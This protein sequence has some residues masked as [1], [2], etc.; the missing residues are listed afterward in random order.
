MTSFYH[1]ALLFVSTIQR[2]VIEVGGVPSR[3]GHQVP[4]A[5]SVVAGGGD[6]AQGILGFGVPLSTVIFEIRCPGQ[7]G[8]Q[9]FLIARLVEVEVCPRLL[10]VLR[11]ELTIE[12]IE[13]EVASVAPRIH[14]AG[15]VGRRV[16]CKGRRV[17][18]R[19]LRFR[20]PVVLVV[21]EIGGECASVFRGDQVAPRVILDVA[22]DVERISCR[23]VPREVVEVEV[24]DVATSVF[25]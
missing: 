5:G 23:E 4:V 10:G 8:L 25:G 18:E 13:V 24:S 14:H 3:I 16:V 19:I 17:P 7:R 1:G 20:L 12:I 22:Q 11:A 9:G 15:P 21:F 6:T 2:V